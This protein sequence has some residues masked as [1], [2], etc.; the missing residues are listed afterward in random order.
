M[1]SSEKG[2]E[3]LR[4]NCQGFHRLVS[5]GETVFLRVAF[6]FSEMSKQLKIMHFHL[7]CL[8]AVFVKSP[9]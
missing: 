6:E 5:Q 2:G 4:C 3:G 9:I 8:G 7:F 1:L